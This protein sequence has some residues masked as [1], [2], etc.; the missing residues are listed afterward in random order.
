[1]VTQSK[2]RIILRWVHIVLG[3]ILMCYIYSPFHEIRAFQLVVKF[4]VLP[5]IA[6][7]GLWIWKFKAFNKFFKITG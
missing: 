3:V 4:T 2:M 1:M 5:L 6:F 7:S